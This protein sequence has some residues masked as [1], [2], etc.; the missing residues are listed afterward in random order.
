MCGLALESLTCS[1][2]AVAALHGVTVRDMPRG[3]LT[4]VVGPNASGK[5][6]LLKCVSG[7][8]AVQEGRVRLD[9]S[10][11]AKVSPR[12]RQSAVCFLPRLFAANAALRVSSLLR[13]ACGNPV[14]TTDVAQEECRV[15]AAL[16]SCGITH[17]EQ[18]YVGE[19]SWGQ[20]TLVS[21][22]QTLVRH[23]EVYLFDEP[24]SALDIRN[25]LHVL[26]LIKRQVRA[27]NA[28][29]V[30]AMQDVN[31]AAR[32]ADQLVLLVEGRVLAVGTPLEV[33]SMAAVSNAYGVDMGVAARVELETSRRV[34][35]I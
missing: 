29:G 23:A 19:L 24:T 35:A 17:L 10:D 1:Y 15:L 28:V 25:E 2:S 12:E 32:F 30:L 20:C 21:V 26:S 13:M 8:L 3:S 7:R 22:A 5:S 16:E 27:R 9:Q 6:T 34:H 4:A 11:L 31:L 33:L 18:A 14:D